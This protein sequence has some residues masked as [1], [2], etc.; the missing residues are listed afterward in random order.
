MSKI[1]YDLTKLEVQEGMPDV[2][3]LHDRIS[4]QKHYIHFFIGRLVGQR[5]IPFFFCQV[6]IYHGPQSSSSHSSLFIFKLS[7]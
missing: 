2:Y 5:K 7:S 4:S 6:K 1:S 3:W